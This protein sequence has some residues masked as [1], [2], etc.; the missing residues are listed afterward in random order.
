LKS[1]A[2]DL[3]QAPEATVEDTEDVMNLK[4]RMAKSEEE[5]G[6]LSQAMKSTLLDVRTLMQ[7]IDNPFNMLKTMGVDKLVNKAVSDVENEVVKQKQEERKKRMA[8]ADSDDFPEKI[9]YQNAPAAMPYPVQAAPMAPAPMQPPVASQPQSTP[10]NNMNASPPGQT[11]GVGNEFVHRVPFEAERSNQNHKLNDEILRR[12]ANTEKSIDSLSDEVL[13]L[14]KGIGQFIEETKP[15]KIEPTKSRH[16]DYQRFGDVSG[17]QSTYYD[18]YVSLI[19]EYLSIK[20]GEEG[21]NQLLL[22]GLYKGWASPRVVKDVRDNLPADSQKWDISDGTM[23]YKV[24]ETQATV[25][26]KILFTSLLGSLD[27]PLNEWKE[28]TQVFLLLA[29][30]KSAKKTD[31]LLGDDRDVL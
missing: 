29:L 16:D 27:K 25:E 4:R 6:A 15:K 8:E 28:M 12:V 1:E 18:T 7:D 2:A 31:S 14:T 10:V 9:V 13:K 17:P 20:Y 24:N 19:A 26:D 22:E 3:D 30:V 23:G 5:M 11:T 21:A